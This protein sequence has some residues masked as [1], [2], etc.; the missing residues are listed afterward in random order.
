MREIELKTPTG[1]SKEQLSELFDKEIE[2]FSKWMETMP[3]IKASGALIAPEKAL[4][5]TYLI[6]KLTGELDGTVL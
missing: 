1:L 2:Q 3:D 4:L 6:R 5:K